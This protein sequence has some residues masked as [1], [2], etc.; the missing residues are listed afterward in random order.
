M[1]QNS[2]KLY[3]VLPN[4][5]KGVREERRQIGVSVKNIYTVRSI[6]KYL[7]KEWF[8]KKHYA[9]RSPSTISYCFGLFYNKKMV[10]VLCYGMPANGRCLMLCTEKYKGNVQE[11]QRVITNDGLEK[12]ALSFFISQTYKY[13]PKNTII[14]SYADPNN[15]HNGY[16]Y[17]SLNFL[18]TGYAGFNKEYLEPNGKTRTDRYV[19]KHLIKNNFYDEKLTINK[20]WENYGGKIIFKQ[21]KHRY[22][23]F[24]A[25]KKI[26][27]DMYRL[28]KWE[29]KQ[30]P[31]KENTNYDASY[32]PIT[33]TS[34]F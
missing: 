15:G 32:K 22:I 13:L 33:Q 14:I 30:Y 20:M 11:L 6:D 31:K 28:L 29:I 3:T 2:N 26:K 7:T 10:G 18:F 19:K 27:K 12:N 23:Y 8:N 1:A 4:V 16:I 5:K 25:S 34:I 24:N 21:P 9:K 17:Q